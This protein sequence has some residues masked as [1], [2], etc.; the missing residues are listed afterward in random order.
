MANLTPSQLEILRLFPPA[1]HSTRAVLEPQQLVDSNGTHLLTPP[2]D[3][4]ISQSS[5]H[6]DPAI[7]GPNVMEFKPSR[8]ID[9]SGQIITPPKGTFL[10]WSGGP[11]ICPGMKMSQVEFVAIMATLF[12]S[13]NCEPL[14]TAGLDKP[15]EL[16][17][18]LRQLLQDSIAGLTLQVR[19][20]QAVQLRWIHE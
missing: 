19:D 18:R 3:V 13:A 7:W 4:Y 8:W 1:L 20:P 9:G 15:E 6:L 14:P 11:R 16:R 12:R 10:P 5:V 2:M 17:Q